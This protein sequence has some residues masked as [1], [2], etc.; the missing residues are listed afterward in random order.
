MVC[1]FPFFKEGGRGQSTPL[2][3]IRHPPLFNYVVAS[4]YFKKFLR[5]LFEGPGKFFDNLQ[6]RI[7]GTKFNMPTDYSIEPED[8]TA[9]IWQIL[10]ATGVAAFLIAASVV[11]VMAGYGRFI[12]GNCGG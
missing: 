10:L 9:P 3:R 4:H 8:K 2:P 11:M 7:P 6:R 5:N 12:L 1:H